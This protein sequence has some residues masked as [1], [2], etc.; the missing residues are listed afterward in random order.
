MIPTRV[1]YRK[2][3]GWLLHVTTHSTPSVTS[4]HSSMS[5][6]ARFYWGTSSPSCSGVSNKVGPLFYISNILNIYQIVANSR[7]SWWWVLTCTFF[8]EKPSQRGTCWSC[9]QRFI[10]AEFWAKSIK[11]NP[12][13]HINQMFSVSLSPGPQ[14]TSSWHGQAP[15]VWKT[16]WSRTERSSVRKSGT[17]QAPVCSRSSSPPALMRM[18]S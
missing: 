12:D 14:I 2:R 7:Y 10:S 11:S 5:R 9:S 8:Y 13:H 18:T 16:W 15:T 3:S 17:S 4:S 6:S 1:L